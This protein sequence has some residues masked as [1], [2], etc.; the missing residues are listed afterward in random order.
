MRPRVTTAIAVVSAALALTVAVPAAQA[1][2]PVRPGVAGALSPDFNPVS[3]MDVT[4]SNVSVD[5]GATGV[6]VGTTN[7]VHVAYTYTLTAS[8]VDPRAKGFTTSLDLYRGTVAQPTNDLSGNNATCEVAST[9]ASTVT[10]NCS[11]T[12]D[13]HPHNLTIPDAGAKWQAI[14]YAYDASSFGWAA[15]GGFTAPTMRR[16]SELTVNASPEPVTKGKTITIVGKL[17]RANWDTH[18]YAG[19]TVQPVKLQ[20]RPKTSSTYTTL[21]TVTTD[22]CG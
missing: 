9:A 3:S 21:K 5:K 15:Q 4:F 16:Y 18:V 20:F 1:A 6:A 8:G 7:I 14:A 13:I 19:Y 11:G 12:I 10:E 17:S 22:G 2:A